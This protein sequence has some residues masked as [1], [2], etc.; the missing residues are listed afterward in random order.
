MDPPAGFPYRLDAARLPFVPTLL[1]LR[2]F[3][4]LA[5]ATAALTFSLVILGAVVRV[6]GSGMG[7]PDWPL[8]YG[9]WLPP[10]E[11]AA[12]LE[13]LHRTLAAL[14]SAASLALLASILSSRERRARLGGPAALL[15]AAL[16]AQIALGAYTVYQSNAAASVAWHLAM[17]YVFLG[18]VLTIARRS[19][20]AAP[21]AP[22]APAA[23]LA[24]G[25]AVATVLGQ[26][27]IGGLVAAGFA[28]RACPDFPTCHGAWLPPLEGLIGLQMT[29]RYAALAVIVAVAAAAFL[30]GRGGPGPAR[31]FIRLA[32]AV[33]VVQVGIG[34]AAVLGPFDLV[35]RVLHQVGAV[36]VF[37][38]SWLAMDA[39]W[40][41]RKG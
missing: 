38:A 30:G 17:G 2:P 16:L 14:V 20:A 41:G 9:Q 6:T 29:H 11:M 15:V 40:E 24:S 36:S 34:I 18:A 23:V 12:I 8:C 32:A 28:G 26:C 13:W 5:I 33:L 4:V 39:L 25:L 35:T 3:P 10:W 27:F 22:S 7:C 1:P 37:M 21:A 19:V 31:T